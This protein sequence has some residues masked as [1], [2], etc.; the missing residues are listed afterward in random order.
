MHVASPNIRNRR[1]NIAATAIAAIVIIVVVT[2]VIP[3]AI[4]PFAPPA[5]HGWHAVTEVGVVGLRLKALLAD[6]DNLDDVAET[7]G[8]TAAADSYHG[9]ESSHIQMTDILSI[10]TERYCLPRLLFAVL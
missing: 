7:K 4:R 1:H 2:V 3:Y 10:R 8:N 6:D 5:A 9:A